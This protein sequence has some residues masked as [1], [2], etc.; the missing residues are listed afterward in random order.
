MRRLIEGSGPS[1]LPAVAVF[2][3]L[4]PDASSHRVSCG[5][6]P[7]SARIG[8]FLEAHR[9]R[10]NLSQGQLLRLQ[11]STKA[12]LPLTTLVD[13]LSHL[14]VSDLKPLV[15]WLPE[16]PPSARKD[17][18]I[19]TIMRGLSPSGLRLLWAG[20]DELQRLAVGEALYSVGSVFDPDLFR[21]KHGRL[22]EF[23]TGPRAN[24][25][26]GAPTRL[27]LFLFAHDRGQCVPIDLHPALAAFVPQPTA[28][29][30]ASADALPPAIGEATLT[31]RLTE[32]DT[33]VDL[34]VML[35]VVEQG[36]MQVADKTSLPTASTLRLL[37]GKLAGGDF[38]SDD[39]P[40]DAR[41]QWIG[42]IKAFAW[43]MLLQAA[44]LVQRKGSKLALTKA[45]LKATGSAPAEVL[46]VIWQ[47]WVN[48][49][50]LDEFSRID[51]I[52]G[53]RA[54]G[55]VMSAVQPRRDAI[56]DALDLCPISA[57]FSVEEFSRFMR[58]SGHGFE[59]ARD[60]WK[61][62]IGEAQYGS[63]GYSGSHDWAVLQYRY[64]LC[65]LFEYAAT[66]GMVDVAFVE[67]SRVPRNFSNMWGTDDLE[68]LSRY[69][70]LAYFRI[71]PLGAYCLGAS[72]CYA[73][74]TP[75]SQVRLSVLPSLQVTVVDGEPSVEEALT[76]DAW[77]V[78][79]TPLSWRLD[80]HKAIAAIERGHSIED[81]RGFLQSRDEQP[82]PETAE[83]F[84]TTCCKNSNA[85][86]VI[87]TTLLIECKDEP[88][89]EF[90]AGHKLNAGLCERVG[91]RRLVVR[92]EHEDKFRAL[93]RTL[94][95]G[96]P[97]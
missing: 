9:P 30:I 68:F 84:I 10:A 38:Y 5:Y 43:P 75:P 77:C 57:W 25:R 18:L 19:G 63:L 79:E 27:A 41:R 45:G 72:E 93:V 32:R 51:T 59:V 1:R 31:V 35:R 85:M 73:G 50:L 33:L 6:G 49:D 74:A 61:L 80:R 7:V 89:A 88:T 81:L 48:S 28:A 97:A 4:H 91:G 15:A 22:P 29:R 12:A 54:S 2:S 87:G 78:Q 56:C 90:V 39:A 17:D 60:P 34:A 16:V 26:S 83:S 71:T 96:M 8:N 76:L 37:A 47:K 21:A 23:S 58:A 44:A 14:N 67:P 70:G 11:L 82:L 94:G 24:G 66:L 69:D 64:V 55:R 95:L 86:K 92:L 52:K 42:P 36:K 40:S 53:Q 65:L 46:R 20:L 13:A 3:S 62:Y